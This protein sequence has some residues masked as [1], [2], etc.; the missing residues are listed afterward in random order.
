MS[1][2]ILLWFA[3]L[4]A[5]ERSRSFFNRAVSVI[6]ILLIS[7]LVLIF[8]ANIFI[9]EEWHT[10][11][12]NR[13]LEYLST[14]RALLDS[15]SLPFKIASVGLFLIFVWLM[16][17]AYR[18]VV[19]TDVFPSNASRWGVMALPLQ[20]GLL[21]LAIRGGLGV[22]PINESAV[23]YSPH[24]FNNH[25]ATN[26]AWSLIHSLLEV[27]ST[28]NHYRFMEEKEAKERTDCILGGCSTLLDIDYKLLENQDSSRRLNV[29]FLVMESH[30]A[31]VVEEL[32]GEPGV[33][34]NLSRLIR[35]GILF[36]NIYSSGYRTDQGLACV[37]GG[38]PAQ[39]DQSIMLQIDK[40]AKL[41]SISKILTEQGYSSAF[42]FGSE[43]TFANLG[44]WLTNQRFEKILSEKDFARAERTQRWG[45]DDNI[46]LQRAALEINQLKEPFFA[47][48]TT[49][50]LHPPY[51][52]PYQS[53]WNGPDER[54]QFLNSAAFAD[55]AIG[56]FF[57]TAEKQSWYDNTLFVL[58]ADH[59]SSRPNGVGLDNPK[60][61]HIP[62]IVFG[63]PLN[64]AKHG[65]RIS[66]FGNHHDIPA[67]VLAM[68][69]L[70]EHDQL[71]WSRSLW[72]LNTIVEIDSSAMAKR[73]E[74][75]YYTNETGLGWANST[76]KGFY[77]FGNNNWHI[78]EG[79]LDSVSRKDALAY[80]QTLY[81]DFLS[82]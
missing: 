44:V 33:S 20:T 74:F 10:L 67:T 61:R 25:A 65:T 75:A 71:P 58:V 51:D 68:L 72:D 1:V 46:M 80:L 19:G 52:V 39:P 29:V 50:S 31:Q 9:Y 23:Y 21:L 82:K 79:H 57:K 8:G 76:G 56:E 26:A 18:L 32:G 63:K 16:W 54:E 59:G 43:L 17:R 22:M 11:L 48:A 34:P 4:A 28:E 66:V 55:Y 77:F 37:L 41:G 49:L 13:A 27:R 45:V 64:D 60:S 30:T 7:I 5:G 36:E 40:A 73:L 15:M 62:L 35:E 38:Y 14:P 70:R 53:K 6:N 69:K 12:N 24:L 42:F 47:T 81:G 78:W 2:P 3:G